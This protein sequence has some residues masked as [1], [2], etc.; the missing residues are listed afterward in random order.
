MIFNNK[1]SIIII[2]F[3]FV[4]KIGNSQSFFNTNDIN[5]KANYQQGV[6]L[7][8]YDFFNYI[9]DD[10]IKAFEISIS[11]EFKG[12]REWQR[13]Y[14]YPSVGISFFHTSLGNDSIYGKAFAVNPFI[15][16]NLLTKPKFKIQYSVGVGLTYATKHFDLETNYANI[17]IASHLNI[18]FNTELYASY[19]IYK[20]LSLI[21]GTAFSH[22]SNANLAEP[23]IGINTWTFLVGAEI[24]VGKKSKKNTEPIS[25]LKYKNYYNFN[26]A[27]GV[28]HTRRFAK[29]SYFS[30][31]VE[32]DYN[33]I[34]NHKFALGIGADLF[35]DNSIPDEMKRAE[36]ELIKE[37]YKYK[38]GI[39]ISQE[40]IFGDVSFILHEGMYIGFLDKL[41]HH[42]FYNRGI[43]R[44]KFSD[45]FF[46]SSAMKTNI[47]VLDMMEVGLGYY[48]N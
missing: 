2:I 18:W 6:L 3:L 14:K 43:L 47:F 9:V 27:G 17:A 48:W 35:Q 12:E 40:I 1:K 37:S 33:R 38:S 36:Y 23:N 8:E 5:L 42:K 45:H 30:G 16:F 15:K 46:V 31:S 34:L 19:K 44:Y 21:A 28:K 41:N 32:F 10:K 20:D 7:F 11:K 25:K 4:L 24:Q 13:L 22:L 26:I 39:H 29:K